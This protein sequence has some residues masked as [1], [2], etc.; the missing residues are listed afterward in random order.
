M[1][2]RRKLYVL[3][4]RGGF[5]Q[6]YEYGTWAGLH[7]IPDLQNPGHGDDAQTE[8]NDVRVVYDG[9]KQDSTS[10]DVGRAGRF[11]KLLQVWVQRE[12]GVV[13]QVEKHEEQCNPSVIFSHL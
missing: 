3:T 12:D 11:H 9:W 8:S 13:G 1:T 5:I 10:C 2:C 7:P 4:Y 6:H